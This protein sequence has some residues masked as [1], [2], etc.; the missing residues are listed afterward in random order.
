MIERVL[1]STAGLACLS[2][3]L[4]P[5]SIFSSPFRGNNDAASGAA[6]ESISLEKG[7]S[8]AHQSGKEI[9]LVGTDARK[10]LL[11]TAHLQNGRSRDYTRSVDYASTPEGIVEVDATGYLIPRDNGR[12]LIEARSPEGL[13]TSRAVI[14]RGVGQASRVNFPNQVVPVFT[15]NGCNSGGCHGKASG[16]NG[17]RLSL[18]GFE[19]EEDYEHLVIEARGRRLFPSAPDRSL[20]LGK[21]TGQIP[22]GGGAPISPDSHEYA[23]LYRWIDQGMPYGQPS[24]PRMQS[25]EVFPPERLLDRQ[26]QQQLIVTAHY[27][28]GSSR[29]V[30]RLVQYESKDLQAAEVGSTGLVG[31]GDLPGDFSIMVRFQDQ[32]AVFRGTE[33]LGVPTG[34]FPEPKNFIDALVFKKLEILGLPASEPCTDLTFLRRA[35]LDIAGRLPTPSEVESYLADGSPDKRTR[36]VDRLL[37]SGDYAGYFAT[38]WVGILRN[39]RKDKSYARGTY[40][41]HVWLRD[42]LRANRPYD[43][44]VSDVIV[45][46]GEMGRNPPTAWYRAAATQEEQVEDMAQVFLGT[47]LRC[48]RCHHHPF[49]KWSQRDYYGV[50]AFFSRLARK[51]SGRLCQGALCTGEEIIFHEPGVAGAAIPNRKEFVRPTPLGEEPLELDVDQDPRQQLTAWMTDLDNPFFARTL[52]NRYW[53]HFFGRGLVEPEDDMR[54]TTPPPPIRS[55]WM[56]WRSISSATV[57][58]CRS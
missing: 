22:H 52:V 58:I 44:W 31:T 53:K 32:V 40:L 37:D 20:L 43:Q 23:L 13:V 48:A 28:D 50:A 12:A 9:Q 38:K 33:P 41:F 6:V 30:T 2:L 24:D 5:S 4:S 15:K 35:A 56:P 55:Y 16:Q 49:E 17:F 51:P 26:G 54:L 10:Q 14:V 42:N 29:D 3:F 39:K 46:S 11:V 34:D 7:G 1:R 25:L 47:Q 19:P 27:T 8:P 36:W 57:T 21:A 45:A 18:L